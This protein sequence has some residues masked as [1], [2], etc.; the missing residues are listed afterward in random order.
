[1][2]SY[3]TCESCGRS[4]SFEQIETHCYSCHRDL[5]SKCIRTCTNCGRDFCG[6]HCIGGVCLQCGSKGH[7]F[8]GVDKLRTGQSRGD[9][10]IGTLQTLWGAVTY[11]SNKEKLSKERRQVDYERRAAI[12]EQKRMVLAEQKANYNYALPEGDRQNIWD[13]VEN[14]IHGMDADESIKS[15]HLNTLEQDVANARIT[16]D[17]ALDKA[18][19]VRAKRDEETNL[20]RI[21]CNLINSAGLSSEEQSKM[22]KKFTKD[23][24]SGRRTFQQIFEQ[25][26]KIQ[27]E[28]QRI[29]NERI[30]G[31]HQAQLRI[32]NNILHEIEFAGYDEDTKEFILGE[33]HRNIRNGSMTYAQSYEHAKKMVKQREVEQKRQE[34]EERVRF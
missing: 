21:I 1:M 18:R 26:L 7:F 6:E 25:A 23:I 8:D 12:D 11:F 22:L 20:W 4:V 5:C 34:E 24:S 17:E 31:K 16:Y 29:E 15:K 30:E 13:E 3:V 14:Q 33:F 32:R 9:K 2:R 28:H 19:G 10:A 27:N